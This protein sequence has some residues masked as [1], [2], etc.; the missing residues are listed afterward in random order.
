MDIEIFPTVEVDHPERP[1]EKM[2]VNLADADRF[3]PAVAAPTITG[4][5]VKS[6]RSKS[7]PK[8]VTVES[9]EDQ[10]LEPVPLD[11][12]PVSEEELLEAEPVEVEPTP[13]RR[14]KSAGGES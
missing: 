4:V 9:V 1:G 8:P 5:S 14:R 7:E 13:K 6:K 2:V 10:V 3:A 11:V 12:E